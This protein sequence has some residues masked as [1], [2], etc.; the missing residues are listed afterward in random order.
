MNKTDRQVFEGV[1]RELDS[2]EVY[3]QSE[4]KRIDAK[5]QADL[6]KW[7]HDLKEDAKGV[8]L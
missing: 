7:L 6:L 3:V 1:L 4:H 8:K 5:T 2:L